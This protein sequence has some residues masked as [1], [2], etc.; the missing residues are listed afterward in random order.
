MAKTKTKKMAHEEWTPE[1]ET[2]LLSVLEN[3][4]YGVTLKERSEYAARVFNRSW[5]ACC[6]RYHYLKAEQIINS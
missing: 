4:Q 5:P 3:E 2:I 6:R 1:A